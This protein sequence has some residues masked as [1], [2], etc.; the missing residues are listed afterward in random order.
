[1][2]KKI[3][4]ALSALG[5]VVA[6]A[7][8]QSPSTR[9]TSTPP[10]PVSRPSVES[11]AA[12]PNISSVALSPSGRYV[13]FVRTIAGAEGD[14]YDVNE[15]VVFDRTTKASDI[16]TQARRA[17]GV[18]ID[19]VS[20]KRDDL[21]L[22]GTLN[23]IKGRQTTYWIPRIMAMSRTGDNQV[24]LFE[25]RTN[26]PDG[27]LLWATAAIRL[28]S[29]LPH[30]PGHVLL[31]ARVE[32]G[33]ALW[34]A[35]VTTGKV[36]RIDVGTWGTTDWMEDV[37]GYPVL[38]MDVLRRNTGTRFMRRAPGEE[39]WTLL[40]EFKRR[41]GSD[42]EDFIPLGHTA[43]PGE[44]LV[45]ARNGND[46]TGVHV[47]NTATGALGPTII[48]HATADIDAAV[49]D[50]GS[51]ALL[52][53]CVDT[54]RYECAGI[55]RRFAQ[56]F[57][58]IDAF[59][60]RKARI[61]ITGTSENMN[62][63]LLYVESPGD[64][65]AYYLFDRN[66]VRVDPLG[67]AYAGASGVASAPVSVVSYTARDG[68]QLW[69]YLTNAAP[70]GQRP[71]PLV[72]MPHGGPESRDRSGFDVWAQFL[73][74]RGYAVFQPNFRG[75]T[76]MGRAFTV[77]GYRQWGRRMQDDITDG[78]KHLIATGQANPARI[79]IFGWSYG[80]Y[81]ALA[82]GATTPELYRC[83][84]SGAGV[85]DL[86]EL[87]SDELIER[88][89]GSEAYEYVVA[90]VGHPQRDRDALEATSPAR[91]AARFQAPVLLLHGDWDNIVD[92]KQSRLMERALK[93]AGKPVRLVVYE[94][95]RHS[96][97]SWRR[98]SRV[99]YL[100]EIETFLG[101]HLPVN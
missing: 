57:G 79:G 49:V 87:L 22:L 96:P 59:F 24:M 5:C 70:V 91:L 23:G 63:W 20:W 19:W 40:Y 82:G 18:R 17:A 67:A 78:V 46:L 99:A 54:Q 75:G 15:L 64:P 42:E 100:K 33:N 101:R 84:I 73:A 2:L 95:E 52:G 21:L 36:E 97:S 61:E 14:P 92:V 10:A 13:A 41:A 44:L 94:H 93:D 77:A 55:D 28:V 3:G 47:L 34:R 7:G 86:R 48:R 71:R 38:R 72:V 56:H 58:A 8:A 51:H 90:A 12:P 9:P 6:I 16:V 27:R 62:T 69:G 29:T 1:M 50:N 31:S 53:Y 60:D 65:P 85:S 4:I 68:S 66:T 76:G 25:D 32:Q 88:G 83:I 43:K 81:A 11:F 89:H 80:G 37:E 74:S 30:D 26:H 39:K 98:E 35:D 45:A